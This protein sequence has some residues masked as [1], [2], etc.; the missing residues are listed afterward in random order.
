MKW[1]WVK[2]VGLF[3]LFLGGCKQNNEAGEFRL[4]V[5]ISEVAP[6]NKLFL[7]YKGEND[8]TLIDSAVYRDGKFIVQ[9]CTPYP[10]RALVRIIPGDRGIPIFFED[11][12]LFF[13]DAMFVFLEEGNVFVSADKALRGARL[14]GT[15]LNDDLQVY[16][17]SVRFYRDWLDGYRK[18][19]G[20]AYR[21]RDDHTLDSL[22]KEMARMEK[23]K[24]EVELNYFDNHLNSIVS[25]DWLKRT[26]NIVR[27]RSSIVSLFDELGEQVKG[28][29]LG[30]Y[31]QKMLDSIPSIELGGV[32]PDF[33]AE[34][35]RGENVRLNDYRGKYV[36][37]DFWAS[38]CGPC[39]KENGNVLKIYNRFKNHGFV[40]IGYS[41]DS[42]KKSW[43]SAVEKDA[44][45]WEQLSGLGSVKADVAKLY[46]VEAI[47]SNFLIDPDGKIV[48]MDLRG[49][50]LETTLEQIFQNR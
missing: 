8:S 43:L 21:E 29:K 9:G 2:V 37:L 18:Q 36:L 41:L 12:V 6:G 44:L 47:P 3:C 34:S 32:A 33:V 7:F 35:A 39:R 31:Y 5:Q 27:E 13:D 4:T 10:Q 48:A 40:V 50:M 15:P 45:P 49:K 20:K 16:T 46:G 25:L 19:F 38:W 11:A 24:R 30:Q 14:S 28:S 22:S 26:Y 17:D 42:S 1:N 23:K